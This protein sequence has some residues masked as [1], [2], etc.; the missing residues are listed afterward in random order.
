MQFVYQNT[1]FLYSYEILVDGGPISTFKSDVKPQPAVL[2]VNSHSFLRFCCD[3][4]FV[5]KTDRVLI[6][7]RVAAMTFDFFNC[8]FDGYCNPALVFA[9]IFVSVEALEFALAIA[10][11]FALEL[12]LVFAL[13]FALAFAL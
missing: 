11:A 6:G 9:P 13:A 7:D 2:S 8:C 10:L 3:C 1:I 5:F 4:S 12:A